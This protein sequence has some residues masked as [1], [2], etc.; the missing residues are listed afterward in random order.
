MSCSTN[1]EIF[2]LAMLPSA[3]GLSS[4]QLA[5]FQR[6]GFLVIADW[7]DASTM[8]AMRA[9]ALAS[10]RADA[11]TERVTVFT[12]REQTRVSDDYFLSSGDKVHYFFEEDAFDTSGRLLRDKE[13]SI[14]K[15]G[16]ALHELMP[17]FKSVSFD[18][19][20]AAVLSSLGYSQPRIAQSMYIFKQAHVGGEVRPHVDGAFLYT[21]PQSVVGFWWPLEDCTLTNGCLWAVPGSHT[22]GVRRR[23]RRKHADEGGSGTVFEPEQ[24][25]TFDLTGAVPLE[26]PAG[27]LVLLHS[28]VVHFSHANTSD[29]SRHA[30]SIHVIEGGKGVVYPAD[31]WLQRSDGGPFP[32]V[33]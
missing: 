10:V 32:A 5:Q 14:N 29:K 26:I 27:A 8:I 28:A 18:P 16:H 13:S 24:E 31:N 30:Y 4:E 25:V 22:A 15:M 11:P 2:S 20:V 19:R 1:T 9:S 7:L 33:Y 21:E 12:T 6:D 17:V 3:P 23:F